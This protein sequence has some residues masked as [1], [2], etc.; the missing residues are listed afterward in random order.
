VKSKAQACRPTYKYNSNIEHQD[1]THDAIPALRRDFFR[2]VFP[3]LLGLLTGI[4]SD[5]VSQ[6]NECPR[7]VSSNLLGRGLDTWSELRVTD[8][9]CLKIELERYGEE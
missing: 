6:Y 4:R 5:L 2:K 7:S 9:S 1:Q 3:F 8:V